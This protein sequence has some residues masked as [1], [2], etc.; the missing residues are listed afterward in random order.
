[1]RTIL[2]FASLLSSVVSCV[3]NDDSASDSTLSSTTVAPPGPIKQAGPRIA[4]VSWIWH[5]C[6]PELN[7]LPFSLSVHV[8]VLS[9]DDTYQ[10]KGDAVGCNPFYGNDQ[11]SICTAS[12][13]SIVRVLTVEVGDG[14]GVDAQSIGLVDCVNG[15][16]E[17]LP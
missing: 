14:Y 12:P 7:P 5:G 3:G 6:G 16:Q 11:L 10:I 4:E 9:P 8:D 1:M 13:D 2:L 17:F 15:K